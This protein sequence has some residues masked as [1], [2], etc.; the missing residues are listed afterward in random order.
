MAEGQVREVMFAYVGALEFRGRMLKQMATLKKAGISCRLVLGQ[1]RPEPPRAADFE[2]PIQCIRV[3]QEEGKLRTLC[4]QF[5]FAWKAAVLIAASSADAVV[6]VSLEALMAG[7]WAKRRRPSLQLVFDSNELHIESYLSRLKRAIWRPVQNYGLR[8]CDA[9]LHAEANRLEYFVRHYPVA[10]KPNV[11]IENFP[12]LREAPP[13]RRPQQGQVRVIYLGGIGP[14]RFTDE[15]IDA[16]AQLESSIQLDLVGFGSK[17][18][19]QVLERKLAANPLRNVRVR[20]PVPYARIPELLGNYDIGVALYRNTDLN[21]YYCAPNKVYDYLMCGLPVIANRYPGLL[22]VLE[23]NRAGVCIGRVDA[24]SLREAVGTIV[25]E[26]R[27][28][29]ITPELRRRFSWEQQEARYLSV[30]RG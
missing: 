13:A 21:N 26:E 18:Y 25:R 19:E 2:F 27:W 20:P 22:S 9:I 5:R 12:Y 11:L 29:N 4:S 10:G 6:C 8:R 15:I 3:T 1:T 14:E 24:A 23:V 17:A 16:F 7:V 30:F 28:K